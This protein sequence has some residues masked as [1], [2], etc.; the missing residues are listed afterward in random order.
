MKRLLLLI[1]I[2]ISAVSYAQPPG[3]MPPGGVPPAGITAQVYGKI[4]DGD[5]KPLADVSVLLMK[6]SRD[7]STKKAK[8]YSYR[9]SPP[10]PMA[11]LILQISRSA[12]P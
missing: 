9:A 1:A 2:V 4:V 5:G 6:T 12:A 3:N 7:S 8:K 10:R 11:I